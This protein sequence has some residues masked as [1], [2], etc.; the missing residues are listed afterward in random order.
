MEISIISPCF[1]ESETIVKFLRKIE[2]AISK[3]D[4]NFNMII[5]DD[6]STDNTLNLLQN[7]QLEC[8]NLNFSLIKLNYNMG[9]QGAI[10]Q[11]LKYASTLESQFTLI[12][13]CDGED[14]PNVIKDILTKQKN[15]NAQIVSVQR[16]KRK[17]SISF[18][19]LYG[20]YKLIFRV[21]TKKRM[22][23][24]NFCL[25]DKEI[26]SV[27]IQTSFIHLAGYLSKL[28]AKHSF[29]IADK[30]PRIAGKSKMN[31]SSLTNHAFKS[32]IEYA[33][34][35]LMIFFRLF[36]I[37]ILMLLIIGSYIIYSKVV[38]GNAISGWASTLG[39]S[40]LN[41]ALICLGFFV[42]G[43]LLVNILNKRKLVSTNNPFK[44]I[45]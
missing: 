42:M 35:L 15:E 19:V 26:H 33:E 40:L 21:I 45:R 29:I 14:D 9:H 18:R 34:Q 5:V 41:T 23:F 37:V 10:Y 2:C 16:G 39:A 28:K 20:F 24:G 36:I 6:C 7:F 3:I 31:L 27:V 22:N 38:S 8:T 17:E 13:D 12:M 30:K 43:L 25:I 4:A 11:G 1:N 44:V 32:F